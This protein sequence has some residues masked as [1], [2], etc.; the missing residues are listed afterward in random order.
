MEMIVPHALSKEVDEVSE[1]MTMSGK[2][3]NRLRQTYL[4]N[5]DTIE[6]VSH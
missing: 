4:C 2:T 6:K 3:R 1:S 5:E